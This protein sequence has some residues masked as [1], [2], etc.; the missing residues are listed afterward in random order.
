[1]LLSRDSASSLPS[2]LSEDDTEGIPLDT[3]I[4]ANTAMSLEPVSFQADPLSPAINAAAPASM[5]NSSTSNVSNR[6]VLSVQYNM[7]PAPGLSYTTH[8]TTINAL[9]TTLLS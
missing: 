5:E 2:I 4:R 6:K 1:M 7:V 8:Q 9:H 3:R